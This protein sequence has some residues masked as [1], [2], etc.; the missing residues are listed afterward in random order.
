MT[1][2]LR[3]DDCIAIGA[4]HCAKCEWAVVPDIWIPTKIGI[5]VIVRREGR[6]L[7]GKRKG[8]RGN[9]EWWF[10]GG[11]PE[12]GEWPVAAARRELFEE[13]GLVATRVEKMPIW[14]YDLFP[15]GVSFITI[16]F[17]ARVPKGEPE[18][19]EPRKCEGW[20][21]VDP[22]DPPTPNFGSSMEVFEV[23]QATPPFVLG[24]T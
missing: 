2:D 19:K 24:R 5:G 21:W 22:Y 16:Y 3:C 6:V 9:G 11:K 4:L 17:E 8:L 1:D 20:Q 23:I 18:N 14:T 13:T 15:D 12:P 10:A 7:M